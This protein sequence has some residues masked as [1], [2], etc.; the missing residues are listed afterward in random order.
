MVEVAYGADLVNRACH[1]YLRAHPTG[2]H[3]ASACPAVVEYVRKYQP[4]LTEH[5]MPIVSPM[6]ATGLAVKQHYGAHVHCV[7][8]GPCVAKKAEI[9]DP[10]IG[11]VIDEVLTLDELPAVLHAR[12]V[13]LSLSRESDVDPP[14]A[15][16]ARIYP[17]PGGM[18]ESAGIGDGVLDPRLIVVSGHEDTLEALADLPDADGEYAARRGADVQGLLRRDPA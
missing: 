8:V 4:S 2:T 12:G 11:A 6:V 10:Q 5:I 17:I 3:I 15:G 14:L 7:F 13:D 18:L 1:D 16:N 9:L